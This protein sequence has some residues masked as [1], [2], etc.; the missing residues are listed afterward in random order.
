MA[1]MGWLQA[2]GNLGV[3]R[4]IAAF[5]LVLEKGAINRRTPK[6]VEA[7]VRQGV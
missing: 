7:V 2:G 1:F 5:V 6:L 4:F 3:R